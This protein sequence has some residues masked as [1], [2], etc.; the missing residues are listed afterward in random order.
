M[1]NVACKTPLVFFSKNLIVH[2]LRTAA[3]RESK[4]ATQ[5]D[6][7]MRRGGDSAAVGGQLCR[8]SH[9]MRVYVQVCVCVCVT[10]FAGVE[11]RQYSIWS[12]TKEL[13][14]DC[15]SSCQL[16]G[17]DT[18]LTEGRRKKKKKEKKTSL[19]EFTLSDRDN[20][21]KKPTEN[22]LKSIFHLFFSFDFT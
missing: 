4:P 5:H 19:H 10:L 13:T 1:P 7:G 11:K 14:L 9:T 8:G 20:G 15:E 18:L 17:E 12:L 22:N 21:K 3:V 2:I 16:T 6:D